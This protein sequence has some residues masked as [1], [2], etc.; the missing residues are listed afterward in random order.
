LIASAGADNLVKTWNAESGAAVKSFS[1]LGDQ[2]LAV[3]FNPE[4]TLV[5]GGA[6][7][8]EVIIW[9]AADA[10]QFKKIAISPGLQT[11][12]SK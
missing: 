6:W 1:G 5:A 9:K 3:A 7:N 2:A 4:G 12:S 11:A 8:G 10:S